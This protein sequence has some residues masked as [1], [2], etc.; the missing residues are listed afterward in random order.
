MTLVLVLQA[1]SVECFAA[2]GERHLLEDLGTRM[3][4]ARVAEYWIEELPEHTAY[5]L[6]RADVPKWEILWHALG[7]HEGF[8]KPE[9]WR[10]V[11]ARSS[12][13][14]VA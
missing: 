12:A 14:A 1:D 6:C 2:M 9:D 4:E 10:G 13:W 7:T 5:G 3:A 8:T 11:A